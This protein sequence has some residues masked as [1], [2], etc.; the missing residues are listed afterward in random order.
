MLLSDIV[1][2]NGLVYMPD[3]EELKL[4][5]LRMYHDTAPAEHLGQAKT[6]ELITR[7]FYWPG[8]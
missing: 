6:L 3:S 8:M 1:L 5:I 7:N 2:Y 4:R